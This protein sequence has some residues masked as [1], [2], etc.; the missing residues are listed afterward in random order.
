MKPSKFKAVWL[1]PN[2]DGTT[3]SAVRCEIVMMQPW[4]KGKTAR[5]A[6]RSLETKERRRH[7][8]K[9]ETA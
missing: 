6:L 7:G 8:R 4:G 9:K 2:I 3:W 1:A 5:A